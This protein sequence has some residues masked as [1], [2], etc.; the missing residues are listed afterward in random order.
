M[1][2]AFMAI[3]KAKLPVNVHLLIASTDNMVSS[4]S[5]K[6]G[7]YIRMYNGLTVEVNNTD[8]EGRLV[9][10]DALTYAKELGGA[11]II[12]AA[13]LTG[14]II[15][16]LGND[17]TGAFTNNETFIQDFLAASKQAGEQAWQLPIFEADEKA[18]KKSEIADLLNTPTGPG[19]IRAAAF[20]KAFVD[21]AT[22]WI[23]LDVAGTS[24]TDTPHELG[25][26]GATGAT[27]RTL[28]TYAKKA[29]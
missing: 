28:Y 12:N 8:A 1:Y 20:L 7:D 25:P 3:V 23:H 5:L 13:T 26:K 11:K 24:E 18:C 10:A 6:P 19:A 15:N 29:I 4:T 21:D 2:G 17:T 14:A 22:P 9:L 27:I 16:A